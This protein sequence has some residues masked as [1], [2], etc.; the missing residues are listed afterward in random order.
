MERHGQ[1]CKLEPVFEIGVQVRKGIFVIRDEDIARRLGEELLKKMKGKGWS[2]SVWENLGW[3][4][5]VDINPAPG[6]HMSVF[7]CHE[8]DEVYMCLFSDMPHAGA[9]WDGPDHEVFSDPNDAVRHEL[10]RAKGNRDRT[11]RMIVLIEEAI[12][13]QENE[14]AGMDEGCSAEGS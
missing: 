2:L 6:V 4:Y 12:R 1:G 5:S 9:L 7:P 8:D 14:D 3:H 13:E 11:N 10:G